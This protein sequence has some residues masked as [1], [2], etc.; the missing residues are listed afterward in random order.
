MFWRFDVLSFKGYI[1]EVT[2]RASG[3]RV[4][5]ETDKYITPYVGKKDTHKLA[6]PVDGFDHTKPVSVD[7]H[8]VKD[9][10]HHAIIT[11]GK[12]RTL[13]PYTYL[14]KPETAKNSGFDIES[15][16]VQHLKHHGL[17]PKSASAAGAGAGTD[18]VLYNRKQKTNHP[19]KETILKGEVKKD[20]TGAFGQ[21]TIHHTPEL[22]WHIKEKNRVNRPEYANHVEKYVISYLNKNHRDGNVSEVTIPHKDLGPANAYLRDHHVDVLH[23]GSHGTY[24]VG[25][26]KTG[27]GLPEFKGTNGKFRVRKKN[28]FAKENS[29]TVQF[30]PASVKSLEKSHVN[31]ENED[32]LPSIKNAL[33]VS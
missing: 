4:Q 3:A 2:L 17:M 13:V 7:G 19:G 18:F 11:Q 12:K 26:D 21:L 8:K 6:K 25:K 31:L 5:Y 23:I 22:G 30:Q 9:G 14:H 20:K 16:L 27:I 28:K 15:R 29:L 32:H 33:G 1:I 10:K 24:S